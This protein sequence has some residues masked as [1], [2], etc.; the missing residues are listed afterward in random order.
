MNNADTI[1]NIISK[2]IAIRLI[3]LKILDIFIF[4]PF[5]Y[6]F[7]FILKIFS[8]SHIAPLIIFI[9]YFECARYLLS[10]IGVSQNST[11][12]YVLSPF[13]LSTKANLY[14]PHL[15][16]RLRITPS[17]F[18]IKKYS[19]FSP[20]HNFSMLGQVFNFFNLYSYS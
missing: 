19:L 8:S 18:S 15:L 3:I 16:K 1:I 11:S 14:I 5:G 4:F 10:P 2:T 20:D 9:S 6:C 17:L 7:L 13:T 12:T